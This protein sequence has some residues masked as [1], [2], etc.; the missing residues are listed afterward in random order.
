MLAA[1]AEPVPGAGAM[2]P[3]LVYGRVG[4][5]APPPLLLLPPPLHLPVRAHAGGPVL[6]K[7]HTGWLKRIGFRRFYIPPRFFC[8][9]TLKTAPIEAS[10]LIGVQNGLIFLRRNL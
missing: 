2:F 8:F 3:A 10:T 9:L 4:P 6:L 5:G 7:T 1:G